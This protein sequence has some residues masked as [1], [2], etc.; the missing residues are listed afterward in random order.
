MASYN[1]RKITEDMV[2]GFIAYATKKKALSK[3][4]LEVYTKT[5]TKY[6]TMQQDQE[7]MNA[8]LEADD[9]KGA[10]KSKYRDPAPTKFLVY[11]ILAI[12]GFVLVFIT[13]GILSVIGM[14]DNITISETILFALSILG[15][16]F[17]LPSCTMNIKDAIFDCKNVRDLHVGD[18]CL[19]DRDAKLNS[20][21][22]TKLDGLDENQPPIFLVITAIKR[23]CIRCIEKNT[24]RFIDIPI[25]RANLL[26]P[27]RETQGQLAT[28]V[29]IRYPYHLPEFTYDD[30]SI[31]EGA[32]ILAHE[33]ANFGHGQE[34]YNA[35]GHVLAKVRFYCD[36]PYA[37]YAEMQAEHQRKMAT[38]ND[39]IGL[40]SDFF[41][42]DDCDPEN[43]YEEDEEDDD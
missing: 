20:Y 24:A 8:K 17:A 42:N 23:K 32:M 4:E 18:L 3:E 22:H 21:L 9:L 29:L 33:Y 27:I 34:V 2:S 13:Y 5:F 6:I 41:N 26:L 14:I 39:V 25:D 16:G 28:N 43:L 15:F 11:N 30:V 10:G 40:W 31:L 12:V 37:S 38:A 19:F 35:L 36:Q 7:A 1:K